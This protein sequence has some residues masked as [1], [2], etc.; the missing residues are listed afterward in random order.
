VVLGAVLPGR[1]TPWWGLA[2]GL[3]IAAVDLGV[4]GRRLPRV[5][6]L[7]VVPQVADHVAYGVVAGAVLSAR[8]SR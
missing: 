4:I 3:A 1:R 6:A 2:G 7:P 5:R 8:R